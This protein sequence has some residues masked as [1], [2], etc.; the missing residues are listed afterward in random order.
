MIHG[1]SAVCS[2]APH[3]TL[4]A[5]DPHLDCQFCV[6]W[7][8]TIIWADQIPSQPVKAGVSGSAA[9]LKLKCKLTSESERE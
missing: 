3:T 5:I 9:V 1:V 7:T 4:S 2:P 6:L 8:T